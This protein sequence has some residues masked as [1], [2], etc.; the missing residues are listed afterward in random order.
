MK[1]KINRYIVLVLAGFITITLSGCSKKFD[2]SVNKAKIET[3]T[4]KEKETETETDESAIQIELKSINLKEIY[5]TEAEIDKANIVVDKFIEILKQKDKFYPI[6]NN[7]S[8]ILS[9]F[10]EIL[11]KEY[12]KKINQNTENVLSRL[13]NDFYKEDKMEIT[14]KTIV[15]IKYFT[16][17]THYIFDINGEN[18]DVGF[19]T[20]RVDVTLAKNDTLKDIKLDGVMNDVEYT[21]TPL[22]KDSYLDDNYLFEIELNQFI[23][24]LT[25]TVLYEELINSEEDKEVDKKIGYLTSRVNVV[26]KSKEDIREIFKKSRGIIDNYSIVEIRYEN[27]DKMAQ[28]I[29]TIGIPN[30]EGVLYLKLIFSRISNKIISLELIK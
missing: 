5:I 27:I 8:A 11:D 17:S 12:L 15:A 14:S 30:E 28:T 21:E 4:E 26:S 29:Y 3:K 20:Y 2:N 1:V 25:N 23:K 7:N 18:G 22:S 16:D 24:V 6:L 19:H 10:E 13:V 9:E